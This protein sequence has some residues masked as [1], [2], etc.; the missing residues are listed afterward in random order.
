MRSLFYF[1]ISLPTLK[2]TVIVNFT[3]VLLYPAFLYRLAYTSLFGG[4]TAFSK[5]AFVKVN[6][7]GTRYW[8]W[9]GEDDDMFKR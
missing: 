7:Y 9:G 2:K 1:K 4:S 6:G 5:E 3:I 8:G